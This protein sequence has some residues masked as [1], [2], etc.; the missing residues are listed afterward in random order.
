MRASGGASERTMTDPTSPDD[1]ALRWDGDDDPTLRATPDDDVPST[2]RSA[3]ELTSDTVAD[4]PEDVR[5]EPTGVGNIALVA[6]GV[7][8]GVYALWTVG[9]VLGGGRVRDWIIAQPNSIPDPMFQASAL[10]VVLAPSL[11]FATTLLIARR[12]HV[13][14]QFVIL[15]LGA[16]L[17][18]PWPFVTVGVIGS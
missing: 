11:W 3:V 17:L 8:G 6:Y 4:E 9:W 16:V 18:V 7:L 1:H 10:L 12:K 14:K 13:W 15:G 5:E 2:K